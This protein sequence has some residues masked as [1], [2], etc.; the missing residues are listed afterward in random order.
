MKI[1]GL[2]NKEYSWNYKESSV[3]DSNRSKL[4][5]K[6]REIIKELFPYDVLLE[7][8]SLPGCGKT[9]LYADFYLPLR[10]LM[11]EID[12]K[13][14][15]QYVKFYHKEKINFYKGIGRDKKKRQWCENNGITLLSLNFD[16]TEQEWRDIINGR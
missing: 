6:A 3:G 15:S 5:L 1:I 8:V 12:G 4:H 13:Q 14:H 2:D 10:K 11:I 9:T 7:E 16:Q